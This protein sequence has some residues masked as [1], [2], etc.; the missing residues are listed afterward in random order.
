MTLLLYPGF[1]C[2]PYAYFPRAGFLAWDQQTAL[3]RGSHRRP[4]SRNWPAPIIADSSTASFLR[5]TPPPFE[6]TI[7]SARDKLGFSLTTGDNVWR[8]N[9]GGF[10]WR[11][12]TMVDAEILRALDTE[13]VL[14]GPLDYQKKNERH[15]G[16][17]LRF[18][19]WSIEYG[20]VAHAPSFTF[21]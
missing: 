7:H 10:V 20:C 21:L 2:L 11:R 4:A 18:K 15:P 12:V 19:G 13:K 16:F 8:A 14:I 6:V 3:V 5:D 1:K 9:I 17:L